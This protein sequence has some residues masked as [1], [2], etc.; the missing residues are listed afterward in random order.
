MPANWKR[1]DKDGTPPSLPSQNES[2]SQKPADV[3]AEMSRLD[4]FVPQVPKRD[5]KDVVLSDAVMTRI[6]AALNRIRYHDKLYNEWNLKQIDPSGRRVAINFFGP[7]GT[8]KTFCAEAIAKRLKKQLISVNYA[9]IE[10]KYVG[11]TPKNITAAFQKAQETDSVLFFDEADSILGK[12]LTNVTQSAD[13]GVNVSRSVMLLQ[14][15][16]FDGVVVFASNLPENYDGAFVRRILAH[17]QFELPDK[18]CRI[19]LWQTLLPAEVPRQHDVTVEW[20]AD[21]SA[22]LAGGDILNVVKLA[23][24]Q[25]VS[26][27]AATCQV[28]RED[29]ESA[30][31]QV[32]DGKD[33]VGIFG[34]E[35]KKPSVQETVISPEE[36]PDELR[37]RYDHLESNSEL[38]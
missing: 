5:L 29:I 13:H 37:A 38:S 28:S 8:G 17:V 6:E 27:P 4:N 10:S 21:Q 11:E 16:R 20:L 34:G 3:T 31:S 12:R 36:L 19:R 14:L 25:A 33:K 15:D 1:L 2:K 30:I 23:A 22:A 9:E 24:S 7:P 26:R 32:R 35:K 18:D